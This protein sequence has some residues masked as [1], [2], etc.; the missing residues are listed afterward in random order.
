MISRLA[1]PRTRLRN[2]PP[3]PPVTP[4]PFEDTRA[5]AAWAGAPSQNWASSA[6]EDR[7]PAPRL[8]PRACRAR[9]L[10]RLPRHERA[11]PRG[12]VLL[13]DL[14]HHPQTD[15]LDHRNREAAPRRRRA[16]R[17]CLGGEPLLHHHAIVRQREVVNPRVG[18]PGGARRLAHRERV[19]R[20]ER[21]EERLAELLRGD[22]GEGGAVEG[23]AARH[24][25]SALAERRDEHVV[26]RAC[27]LQR[28]VRQ[29]ELPLRLVCRAKGAKEVPVQVL[30]RRRVGPD[31]RPLDVDVAPEELVQRKVLEA[32]VKRTESVTV[33]VSS[34]RTG[35]SERFL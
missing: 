23:G 31:A 19:I 34:T 12:T 28:G 4:P 3:N 20:E 24:R 25:R 32:L 5:P 15:S 35:P 21:V 17:R 6:R 8:S 30:A 29:R 27:Q 9:E 16:D 10:E 14:R 7:G 18:R 13:R 22:P 26:N 11:D 2:V 1:P 33:F